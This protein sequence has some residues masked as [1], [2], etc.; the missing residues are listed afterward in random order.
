MAGELPTL[1][2]AMAIVS[3]IPFLTVTTTCFTKIVVILLILRNA[4]GIQQTPPNLVLNTLSVIVTLFVMAPTFR[5]T[6]AQVSTSP[7][8]FKTVEEL[9][10]TVQR[11][12]VPIK[13]FLTRHVRSDSSAFFLDATRRIWPEPS[14]L[15]A[16]KEDLVILVPAFLLSELTR[17][18]ETGFL[19][20]IPFLLID[21]VVSVVLVAIGM[22]MLSPNVISTPFKLL[23]FVA[24]DGWSR[25]VHGLILSYAPG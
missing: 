11:S 8:P 13:A 22:Q 5:E 1:I 24:V 25:L 14:G 23:L 17:A 19:L 2:V 16:D 21:F 12:S 4:L 9:E 18:F 20:Y 15:S 6:Y 7:V 3:L 10:T